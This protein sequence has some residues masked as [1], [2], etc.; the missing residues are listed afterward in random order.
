MNI[1]DL[2][3]KSQAEIESFLEG[4]NFTEEQYMVPLGEEEMTI[5]KSELSDA[6]VKKS[7]IEEEIREVKEAFKARLE[8]LNEII[9]SSVQQLKTR[10]RVITGRVYQVTDF[11]NKMMHAVDGK[12]NVL[13]SRPLKPEERQYRI[14]Q[15]T[16][17]A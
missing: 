6:S 7:F 2:K 12:G 15:N 5:I 16:K 17:S 8:P 4:E 10:V 1:Y 13:N 11:D 9:S 3:K 14:P